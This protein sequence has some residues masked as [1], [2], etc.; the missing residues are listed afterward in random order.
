MANPVILADFEVVIRPEQQVE[1]FYNIVARKPVYG[2]LSLSV[3]FVS[4]DEEGVIDHN[5]SGASFDYPGLAA[6]GSIRIE[7][8]ALKGDDKLA[9][10]INGEC[11]GE[12]FYFL[13]KFTLEEKTDTTAAPE[14]E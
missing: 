2:M 10:V 4:L 3:S 12:Q 14:M 6:A 5:Y 11:A 7:Y 8:K 13:K 1:L 9:A